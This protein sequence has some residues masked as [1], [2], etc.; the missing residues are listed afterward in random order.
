MRFPVLRAWKHRSLI[1][2]SVPV[3]MAD[4]QEE[5][6]RAGLTRQQFLF[7]TESREEIAGILAAYRDRQAASGEIRRIK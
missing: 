4:R 7:T 1:V 3:Y 6:E 2:N 5:L